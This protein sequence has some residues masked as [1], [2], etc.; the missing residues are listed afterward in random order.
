MPHEPSG[1]CPPVHQAR[2]KR[3]S[4]CQQAKPLSDFVATSLGPSSCR[5]CRR[6]VT[7]LAS[8]RW[9][10]AMR[11]LIAAHPE[12]WAG[13]LRLVQGRPHVPRRAEGSYQTLLARVQ[14]GGGNAA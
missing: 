6:V 7:R 13:L 1:S 5:D 3:C 2:S 8:R 4:A 11:L 9:A 12:E 14:G 10:A